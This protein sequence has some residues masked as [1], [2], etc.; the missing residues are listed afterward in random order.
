LNNSNAAMELLVGGYIV[1][2]RRIR[3]VRMIPK[4]FKL[5][6]TFDVLAFKNFHNSENRHLAHKKAK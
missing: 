3:A 6:P 1:F 4:K 5:H 2:V